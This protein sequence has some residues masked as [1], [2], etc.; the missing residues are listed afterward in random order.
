M[1]D[2]GSRA[3]A[4]QG[5][6]GR[7]LGVHGHRRARTPGSSACPTRLGDSAS[8]PWTRA[9]DVR[10]PAPRARAPGSGRAALRVLPEDAW[11]PRGRR[12]ARQRPSQPAARLG[13]RTLRGGPGRTRVMAWTGPAPPPALGARP[14]HLGLCGLRGALRGGGTA[15]PIALPNPQPPALCLLKASS[16]WARWAA[17]LRL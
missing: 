7:A 13:P 15:V 3:H 14:L 11:S 4:A 10:G 9:D 16:P 17:A 8:G 6:P 2:A 1:Q 5:S 12:R